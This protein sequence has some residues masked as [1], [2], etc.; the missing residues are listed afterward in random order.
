MK[1]ENF[2]NPQVASLI[3][4]VFASPSFCKEKITSVQSLNTLSAKWDTDLGVKSETVT[5][6][7][8]QILFHSMIKENAL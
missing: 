1:L 8:Y 2:L 6:H 5:E 7:L 4:M 3:C